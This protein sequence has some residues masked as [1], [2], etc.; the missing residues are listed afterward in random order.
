MSF[1]LLVCIVYIVKNKRSKSHI[2]YPKKEGGEVVLKEERR[3]DLV[4]KGESTLVD[5]T[6]LRDSSGGIIMHRID[7]GG[8]GSSCIRGK[9]GWMPA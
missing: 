7:A 9:G 2:D 4:Q 6:R 1:I 5:K 8:S 3:E